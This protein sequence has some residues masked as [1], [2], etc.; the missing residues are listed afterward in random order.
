MLLTRSSLPW[1]TISKTDHVKAE[2]SWSSDISHKHNN[3]NSN[4]VDS[5]KENLYYVSSKQIMEIMENCM[6][7]M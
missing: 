1:Q 3:Q 4:S 2:W 7:G 6:S 5:V